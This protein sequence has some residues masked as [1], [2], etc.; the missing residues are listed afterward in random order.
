MGSIFW[1]T[2]LFIYLI[3]GRP[4]ELS[5]RAVRARQEALSRGDQ[6]VT[7]ALTLGEVLVQPL[8][9]GRRDLALRYL[10]MIRSGATVVP[11]DEGTAVR[12]GQLRADFPALRP[13]DALLG[14]W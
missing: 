2:N 9:A 5:D 8:R 3:E 6:L 11:F 14:S 7:S 1:D 12:F 10:E 4:K 13:P